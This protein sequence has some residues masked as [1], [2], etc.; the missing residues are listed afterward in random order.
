M[1]GIQIPQ[2]FSGDKQFEDLTVQNE[3]AVTAD[4]TNKITGPFVDIDN[5]ALHNTAGGGLRFLTRSGGIAGLLSYTVTN[6]QN[7]LRMYTDSGNSP[8]IAL[9]ATK[10]QTI[11]IG[12]HTPIA[13][14]DVR[15][16]GINSDAVYVEYDGS[17]NNTSGIYISGTSA[18]LESDHIQTGSGGGLLHLHVP[19][20]AAA[21]AYDFIVARNSTGNMFYVRG[22]GQTYVSTQLQVDGA[23]GIGTFPSYPLHISKNQASG[24]VALITN[25][26][27]S[28]DASDDIL[29]DLQY[30]GDTN[31]TNARY[32]R[33]GRSGNGFIG[34]IYA[35]SAS[36]VFYATSSDARLKTV[37]GEISDAI[38]KVRAIQA[39]EFTWNETGSS[40]AGFLAQN[41][42]DYYPYAVG[43]PEDED[44]MNWHLDYSKMVPL[45]HK[46]IQEQQTVI[47]GLESRL[48]A[49]ET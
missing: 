43:V 27:T 22:T 11:A 41:V 18:T 12:S 25:P 44:K 24:V 36:S 38:N 29:L 37:T 34:G 16:S 5:P 30:S 19:N 15:E 17:G 8:Q 23:I 47:E 9:R 46:A 45:L 10:D 13:R 6:G 20:R 3:N 26:T 49:L 4:I 2:N 31:P 1:S 28:A 35:D 14:L 33:F 42:N 40:G 39:V 21:N 7:E 48:S 32:I